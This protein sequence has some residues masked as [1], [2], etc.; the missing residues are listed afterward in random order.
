MVGNSPAT[1]IFHN[2]LWL[3]SGFTQKGEG[4][5]KVGGHR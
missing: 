4:D 5:D 3:M 1:P 2:P